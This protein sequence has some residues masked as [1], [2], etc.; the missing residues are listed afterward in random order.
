MNHKVFTNSELN[1]TTDDIVNFLSCEAAGFDYWAEL[2]PDPED[3]TAARARVASR[4]TERMSQEYVCY[5]EVLAEILE[6]GGSLRVYD[7]EEDKDHPMTMALLLNGFRLN[8]KNRPEDASIE[9]GDAETADCILQY[10]IFG[11][12]IYG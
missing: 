8:A 1:I 12:V 6:F 10:A 9:D 3:Y 11:D 7:I 5:E 2:C 4:A